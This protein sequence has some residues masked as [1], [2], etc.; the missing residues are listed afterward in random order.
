MKRLLTALAVGAALTAGS[1]F[2]QDTSMDTM[3]SMIET[4]AE[5]A[6][7]MHGYTDVDVEDLS[8]S[9]VAAIVL[10]DSDSSD[11]SADMKSRIGAIL[12]TN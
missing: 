12:S 4:S 9:Q 11:N 1:A 7:Q 5:R 2:A 10:A 3:L 8:F 6:L